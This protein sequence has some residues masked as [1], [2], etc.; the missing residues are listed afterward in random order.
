MES[1]LIEYTLKKSPSKI[2][3]ITISKPEGVVKFI[4]QFYGDDIDIYESFFMVLLNTANHTIGYV[5]ISQGGI[6]STAVDV[7]IVAKYAIDTLSTRIIICHNHPSG[8]TKPSDSDLRLTEKL[9]NGLDVFDIEVLDH[10]ILT[11]T[12][13]ASLKDTNPSSFKPIK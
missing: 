10:I 1:N 3:T 4:R 12:D 2:K 13:F 11:K 8:N 7:R 6:A 9:V 5:K